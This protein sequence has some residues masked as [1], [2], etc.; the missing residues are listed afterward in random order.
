MNSIRVEIV[1]ALADAQ[2]ILTLQL[3]EGIDAGAALAASGIVR[4]HALDREKLMLGS[5][6]KR[7]QPD[8]LLRDGDRVEILRPLAAHPND[9][10]RARARRTRRR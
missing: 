2:D 9:A 3:P 10:R 5:G 6:G 8:H 1:Y 4:R 7:I